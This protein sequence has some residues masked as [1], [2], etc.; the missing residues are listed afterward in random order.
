LGAAAAVTSAQVAVARTTPVDFSDPAVQLTLIMKMRAAT[1]ERLC[2][3]YV[4]G[5][6]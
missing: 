3:G 6:R 2:I 5:M 4:T 1:D